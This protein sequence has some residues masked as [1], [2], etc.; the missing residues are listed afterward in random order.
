MGPSFTTCSEDSEDRGD[1][2]GLPELC[3]ETSVETKI[4]PFLP[5]KK[6]MG[7]NDEEMHW[8]TDKYIDLCRA[9]RANYKL[10]SSSQP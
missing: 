10:K 4:F 9:W 2:E 7:Q 1:V 8:P 3:F 6:G 5:F